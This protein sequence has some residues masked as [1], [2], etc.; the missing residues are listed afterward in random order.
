VL[1][2]PI[3]WIYQMDHLPS[4]DCGQKCWLET[5]TLSLWLVQLVLLD[6]I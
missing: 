2:H 1:L 3:R 6:N 4:P 5:S